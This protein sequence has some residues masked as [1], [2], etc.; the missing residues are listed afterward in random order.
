MKRIAVLLAS[1]LALLAEAAGNPPPP[2]PA[3]TPAPAAPQMA[4]PSLPLPPGSGAP[5]ADVPVTAAMV[6]K[7]VEFQRRM[8]KVGTQQLAKLGLS[9]TQMRSGQSAVLVNRHLEEAIRKATET[10]RQQVGLSEAELETMR[11][12]A[13]SVLVPRGQWRASGGDRS[14]QQLRQRA[15]RAPASRREELIKQADRL[16]ASMGQM[17]DAK[18]ARRR[19][20]DTAVDLVIQ[21]EPELED[22]Q[23][24]SVKAGTIAFTQ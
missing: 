16:E 1:T 6:D 23:A 3:P 9:A 5:K 20:G 8:V 22:I 10:V 18:D 12:L 7:Y 24:K 19:Y 17:R 14:L 15:E 21:H 4:Y 13:A 11:G 2:T